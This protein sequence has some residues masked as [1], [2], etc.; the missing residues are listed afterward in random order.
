LITSLTGDSYVVLAGLFERFSNVSSVRIAL[1]DEVGGLSPSTDVAVT[2]QTIV[3]L[4]GACDDTFVEN[5][6]GAGL[7][8]KPASVGATKACNAGV[9]PQLGRLG[10]FVDELGPRIVLEGTDVDADVTGY[11]IQFYDAQD[12]PVE[13]DHD[14]VADTPPVSSVTG[15]IPVQEDN[16][17]FVR[18]LPS[19][20]LVEQVAR[21]RVSVTDSVDNRS[22]VLVADREE[23]PEHALGTTCDVRMFNRCSDGGSCVDTGDQD[24]CLQATE[25]KTSAC[26]AALVLSPSSGGAARVRGTL[27]NSLWDAPQGCSPYLNQGDRVVRLVLTDPALRVTLSTDHPYTGFDSVIYVLSSCTATP[28]VDR[29]NAP[30]P[31][32]AARSVLTLQNVA[33]G[34]YFVVVDSHRSPDDTSDTFELTATVE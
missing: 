12:A 19:E 18:L 4:G 34:E 20:V 27:T 17:F 23:A 31:G 10:Y 11:R 3:S 1:M 22:N 16:T 33:A 6:C 30:T 24:R 7:G 32:S 21:V 13:I 28:Q 5:R 15:S 14:I 26:T 25:A 8:C 9:A 29:C 2:L